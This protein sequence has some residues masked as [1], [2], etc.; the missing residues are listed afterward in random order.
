[1]NVVGILFDHETPLPVLP[2]QAVI[3]SYKEIVDEAASFVYK[4]VD[5]AMPYQEN[6]PAPVLKF[7][8]K[9][10][11]LQPNNNHGHHDQL[12]LSRERCFFVLK[13]GLAT[14]ITICQFYRATLC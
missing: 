10:F 3:D 11:V 5:S 4:F 12:V 9:R 2:P 1:M 8:E 14:A 6:Y 13:L 7:N